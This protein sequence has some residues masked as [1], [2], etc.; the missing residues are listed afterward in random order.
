MWQ[1]VCYLKQL[2]RGAFDVDWRRPKRSYRFELPRKY[3]LP[4]IARRYNCLGD[5]HDLS[6]RWHSLVLVLAEVRVN[7]EVVRQVVR[8]LETQYQTLGSEIWN[9][10]RTNKALS[11]P[12]LAAMA[13]IREAINELLEIV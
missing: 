11:Q 7:D 5:S 2:Y 12:V 3:G 9:R 4:S 1:P 10:P 13:S 8:N 6:H